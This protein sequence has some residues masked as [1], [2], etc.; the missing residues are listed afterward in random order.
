MK[1]QQKM[2]WQRIF[3][4]FASHLV[5]SLQHNDP[6]GN[7]VLSHKGD[8]IYRYKEKNNT[9][10]SKKRLAKKR[11]KRKKQARQGKPPPRKKNKTL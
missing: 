10:S 1:V 2:R 11:E 3:C 8:Q 5:D 9:R 6:P 7:H 4:D